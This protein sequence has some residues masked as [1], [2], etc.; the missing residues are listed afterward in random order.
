MISKK[1]S[2]YDKIN[3]LEV[4]EDEQ[5]KKFG[6]VAIA[7]KNGSIT[8]GARIFLQDY[9]S[10]FLREEDASD[11][12]RMNQ[13]FASAIQR[14]GENM[15]WHKQDI[16][17]PSTGTPHI[18]ADNYMMQA[19]KRYYIGRP[20]MQ[21]RSYLFITKMPSGTDMYVDKEGLADF[22]DKVKT[23]FNIV[24]DTCFRSYQ[25]MDADA[26]MDYLVSMTSLD[27]AGSDK[28]KVL[29]DM[30]FERGKIGDYNLDTYLINDN[31]Q[32]QKSDDYSVNLRWSKLEDQVRCINSYV[33]PLAFAV[34]AMHIMN[35]VIMVPPAA[36]IA[37]DFETSRKFKAFLKRYEEAQ[38]DEE[39]QERLKNNKN[40]GVQHHFSIHTLTL[41]AD[42]RERTRKDVESA[43]VDVFGDFV[44][45]TYNLGHIWVNTF[46]AGASRIMKEDTYYTYLSEACKYNNWEGIAAQNEK[47]MIMEDLNGVPFNV[48]LTYRPMKEGLIMN[49]NAVCVGPSGSG[50]SVTI[51]DMTMSQYSMGERI[52]II[53][54]MRSYDRVCAM[55]RG[56]F[57]SA[58]KVKD[59]SLNP[60]CISDESI[61]GEGDERIEN[62]KTF[63]QFI[64]NLLFACWKKESVTPGERTAMANAV[65]EFYS[66][67]S[68]LKDLNRINFTSFYEYFRDVVKDKYE[69]YL[70]A[71]EFLFVTEQYCTGRRNGHLLN[72]ES[73]LDISQDRF[74]V[75]EMEKILSDEETRDIVIAILLH[76]IA[77]TVMSNQKRK[78]MFRLYIDEAWNFLKIPKV[79]SFIGYAY[80]VFRKFSSGVTIIVQHIT[81]LLRFEQGDSEEVVVNSS[82]K[83]LLPMEA[84]KVREH[85][86]IVGLNSAQIEMAA[87]LE[88]PMI[89]IKQGNVARRWRPVLPPEWYTLFNTEGSLRSTWLEVLHRNNTTIEPA[90]DEMTQ[91]LLD[92]NL[93]PQM[94]R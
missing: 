52:I 23:F 75:F 71:S 35:N 63:K 58:E 13:L 66:L 20:Y 40:I 24:N 77:Q 37:K 25:L 15:V 42:H 32:A 53:D 62:W 29:L 10:F 82:T 7:G 89:F 27:F 91:Y 87:S 80:R 70:D 8:I 69:K 76:F 44:K 3:V 1:N 64:V 92:N 86:H 46:G 31:T 21:H 83:I 68:K 39:F 59:L 36:Q 14:L 94:K 74:V 28:K 26:Y 60:F 6:A 11:L 88:K 34:N 55:A 61:M 67:H 2:F 85:G 18:D 50:K 30:D 90:V 17:Y 5:S 72:G 73:N 12:G 22:R 49:Y 43:L 78:E 48:D 93:I 81:D 45:A 54:M 79:G 4:V 56:R 51:S 16:F 65:D 33:Y 38:E 9:H 47:G 19:Q 41:D 57:I 84:A